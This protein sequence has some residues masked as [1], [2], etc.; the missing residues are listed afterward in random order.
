MT[1]AQRNA[2]NTLLAMRPFTVVPAGKRV[3]H[4]ATGLNTQVLYKLRCR[5]LIQCAAIYLGG[6]TSPDLEV[7][8]AV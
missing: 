5:G 1:V 6:C 7:T 3:A 2:L 4:I 8:E